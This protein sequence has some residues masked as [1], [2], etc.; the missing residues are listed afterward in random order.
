MYGMAKWVQKISLCLLLILPGSVLLASQYSDTIVADMPIAYWKLD[1]TTGGT[2]IDVIAGNNATFFNNPAGGNPTGV[3]YDD[4]SSILLNGT[5]QYIELPNTGLLDLQAF[6]IEVW[7]RSRSDVSGGCALY[8]NFPTGG[9]FTGSGIVIRMPFNNCQG[10]FIEYGSGFGEADFLYWNADGFVSLDEWHHVVITFIYQETPVFL[11]EAQIFIDGEYFSSSF[12]S[13][14]IDYTNQTSGQPVDLVRVGV[15]VNFSGDLNYDYFSGYLDELAFYDYVL[16]AEQVERHYYAGTQPPPRITNVEPLVLGSG[17]ADALLVSFESDV[18]LDSFTIDDVMMSGPNGDITATSVTS[19]DGS[20]S[21]FIVEIPPQITEGNYFVVVGPSIFGKNGLAM[22]QDQDGVLGEAEDDSFS[23]S[24]TLG[25]IDPTRILSSSPTGLGN[26]PVASIDIQFELDVNPTSFTV[27]DIVLNGPNGA[28]VP[29]SINTTDNLSFSLVFTPALTDDGA[30]T[31]SIGPNIATLFGGGMDQDQDG[32]LNET[33]DDIY[34]SSFEIDLTPPSPPSGLNYLTAPQ[35]NVTSVSPINLQGNRTGEAVSIRLNDVESV[36]LGSG[37]WSLPLNLIEGTNSFTLQAEDLAGNRSDTVTLYFNFDTIAPVIT[38]YTPTDGVVTNQPT[39]TI[40]LTYSETGSGIDQVNSVFSVTRDGVAVTGNWISD[41]NSYRFVPNQSL[42]DGIYQVSHQLQDLAGHTSNIVNHSFTIDTIAPAAPLVNDLPAVTGSPQLNVSGSKEAGS[43]ILL[44]GQLLVNRNDQTTWAASATLVDGLNTLSFTARDQAGNQSAVTSVEVTFDDNAPG[45][46]ALQVTD[47]GNGTSLHLDWSSYDE[48]ANGN[49]IAEYAVY[50]ETTP[51]TSVATLT[52]AASLASGVKQYTVQG[53]LSN[54]AYY[55]AVVAIDTQGNSLS[56][57]TPVSAS[58]TDSQPPA[59]ITGLRIIPTNTSLQI[60]WNAPQDSDLAGYRLYFNNDSGSSIDAAT[61]TVNRSGLT[62]ATGY[63]VRITALDVSGNES[64]GVSTTAATLL[65]NPTGLAAEGQESRALLTWNAPSPPELVKQIAV[66]EAT[67]NFTSIAGMTPKLQLAPGSTSAVV[68]G[69][70]NG[71]TH[72]FAVTTVNLSDG[73]SESVIT[74]SATPQ[75]DQ[76]GPL[77]ET[78]T[79]RGSPFSSGSTLS[80]VGTLNV[81]ASDT[82][83]ISRIEFQLDG[84]PLLTDTNGSDGY[85]VPMSPVDLADGSHSLVIT[86]YDVLENSTTQSITFTVSLAAPVAP[87]IT[88]PVSGDVTNQTTI[89]VSG[90]ASAQTEVVIRLNGAQVAGPLSLDLDHRF[91]AQV[92]LNEGANTLTAVAQNRGGNSPESTPVTITLDAQVPD[93]PLGLKAQSLEQGQVL[94]TWNPASDDRV[95]AYAV[96]RSASPFE[97]VTQAELANSNPVIDNRFTDLPLTEG[98]FYY[99]V[100]ALNDLDTQSIPS[101][102]TNA[103]ADGTVPRAIAIRY[104]PTGESDAATGRMAAGRVDVEVEVNEALLTTPFL[105]ITPDGG[106]PIGVELFAESDTLY[107]GNFTITDLTPSGT[108]YAVFSARDQVGNRGSDIDEGMSITIDTAG[109]AISTLTLT[110]ASPI[111]ND[112][113]APVEVDVAFT[114]DQ[115]V[116]HGTTPSLSYL[117]SGPGRQ[118]T[119][120]DNLTQSDELNWSGSFQ[121]PADGGL[122][123]AEI[124]SFQLTARDDLNTL[125]TQIAGQNSYQVYQGDLPPLAIPRNLSA[126]PQPGGGVQLQWD[127][128]EGAVEY[129]LYRQAPGELELTALQR[130]ATNEFIETGLTDGEYQYTVASVR[131]ANGEEGVSGQAAPVTVVADS[132]APAAPVSLS[133]ELVGAGIQALWQAPVGGSDIQ[134]YNIY[135]SSGTVL[136]NITG[137]TPIQTDITANSQGILGYLDLTPDVNASVYAVTAVD[138]AGNESA[139]STSA[140]LNVELLPIS[141]LQVRQVD[142]GYPLV[143]WSHSSGAMSGYNLYLDGAAVPVNSALLTE[144]QYEDQGYANSTRQYTISA[145]DGN[146]VESLGRSVELPP[147]LVTLPEERNIHRGIMNRVTYDV[148]NPTQTSYSNLS[149]HIDLE[150][151]QHSSAAFDLAAGERRAVEV[152]IGGYETLPDLANIQ[153]TLTIEPTSGERVELVENGQIAVVDSTLLLRLETRAFTRGATGEMRFILENTSD[154]VTEIIT[155][156]QGGQSQEIRTLL[157]DLDGNVLTTAPFMQLLGSGVLTL[158]SGDTVARIHPGEAYTSPWFFLPIPENAPD[159]ARAIVQIDQFHYQL[160]QSDH[161]AI[162]GSQSGQSVSLSE[163]PYSATIT[164]ITPQSSYGDQP[165][166]IEGQALARDTG[167]PL[168]QVSVELVF[169]VSGFETKQL[170]NSGV[171][172]SFSLEYTPKQTDAGVFILS[173]VYPGSLSRPSQGQ[174]TINRVS[175]SPINLRLFLAKNYQQTFELIQASAGQGTTATNLRLEYQAADQ[176]TGQYPAGLT[177]TPAAP[178]TLLEDQTSPL[179]FTIEGDNSADP[180]GN[181]V[182]RVMSDE[183]GDEPLS[184]INIDYELSEAEPAL[185]FSPNYVETGVAH[186]D[187]VTESITLENR[188]LADLTDISIRLL[189]EYD[190]PAPNWVY[191]MSPQDQGTLTIGATKQIQLAA[192]PT[193]L[194]PDGIYPLKLRVESSNYPTTDINVFV[195]VTQSGVGDALFRASDIY[196]ATLDENGDPI[197]GLAGARIRLQH[198][199]VLS[200]EHSGTTDENGEILFSNLAAGRY[201]FRASA[202]NHKDLTGRLSVKPGITTAQD[203]FLDFDLITVEWSV[204]EIT[205]EDRYEITLQ[206][207]FETDVPAAVVVFEPAGTTIPDMAVGDVFHGELRLTN[208]GL[209]R[210]DNLTFRTPGEDGYYRYEFLGSLP[211]SLEAKGSLV[212]PYRIT[213]LSPYEADG[214][215]SG[216][217]CGGYSA[218]ASATYAYK[219]ENGVTS[220]GATSHSWSR[221]VSGG[222]SCGGGTSG[223]GPGGNGGGWGGGSGGPTYSS[224]SG[225]ECIPETEPCNDV[226]CDQGKGP[227]GSGNGNY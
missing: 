164:S 181:L 211:E 108:A 101:N 39:Q 98:T 69:L 125:G 87:T 115:P 143:S 151:H 77:L 35:T 139:P 90:T 134:S 82:S 144:T 31:L 37:S 95:V 6:S 220:G 88:T 154:V 123:E 99:R 70:S 187:T 201:R 117:L 25:N 76:D 78:I 45:P 68:T 23:T 140:Y 56:D 168:P 170:V 173:A 191:L 21:Q 2:A 51:Y 204:T 149:L 141:S 167:A 26:N 217:G 127:A 44:N 147:L 171:D 130:V 47:P 86:A 219:C 194:V 186:D 213:A 61:T 49:D 180:A 55:L 9:F 200:I 138:A 11:N 227:A 114:L 54:Q 112:Q 111:Q 80:E 66:Y 100:V 218:G 20:S 119:E 72:Y 214:S 40:S 4:G 29:S 27:D 150:G 222:S 152:I 17:L 13:T 223:G 206:A 42:Q 169:T 113:A 97:T 221:P 52:A 146:S 12:P 210:A 107:R 178:V 203:L 62:P 174:F 182:L 19:N 50:I 74:V 202:A 75:S 30:Y 159:N 175:I 94:L 36:T 197:P 136:D 157:E 105:S 135:R 207:T 33:P 155:A 7:A 166:V 83:G 5:D 53:L 148:V 120:I 64:T 32:I 185:Y 189:N 208:Y 132:Q 106:I 190:A 121:L 24:F 16:T 57:V 65:N 59:E 156:S 193:Y 184:I 43:E 109:P 79:Y 91:Q 161:L 118:P 15:D 133:L 160:G 3:P 116:M 212:I 46:V 28:V 224:M 188:G 110:P 126:T 22:D 163:P 60:S 153:T 102:Q 176:P 216:G 103:V 93:T 209:I 34:S 92:N 124:L 89:N 8:A 196:T 215:G 10:D 131:Q 199:E 14:N 205:I 129:Q 67:A 177:L 198:E 58:A 38:G 96:Y 1:Q 192:N 137:L 162:P 225:A 165:I 179:A 128:V 71:V 104:S 195:A 73:E 142:G 158:G 18:N 122:S 226:C 81:T 85:T 172:G 145:I 84:A 63:P 41:I 48:Q 183:R